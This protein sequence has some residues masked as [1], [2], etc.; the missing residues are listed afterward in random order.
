MIQFLKYGALALLS[1]SLILT[2]V[3]VGGVVPA[4][5]L[6]QLASYV[7]LLSEEND[8]AEPQEGI[9]AEQGRNTPNQDNNE[10]EKSETEKIAAADP[11]QKTDDA[12]EAG[13]ETGLASESV[14]DETAAAASPPSFDLL[15][16]EPDGSLVVSGQS[17]RGFTVELL[18]GMGRS[19]G[20]DI[21]GG[22]GDFVII[23][24][25]RLAVGD[26]TL[27]LAITG[28]D[29]R[30]TLSLDTGVIHIPEPGKK[31]VLALVTRPDEPSRIVVKPPALTPADAGPEEN[32]ETAALDPASIQPT[33]V[34]EAVS[35]ETANR[36]TEPAAA[37]EN[38]A[39]VENAA[40]DGT[41]KT[42]ASG[43]IDSRVSQE[44]PAGDTKADD[45]AKPVDGNGEI[46]PSNPPETGKDLSAPDTGSDP[47]AVSVAPIQ[48]ASLPD[49]KAAAD[50]RQEPTGDSAVAAPDGDQQPTASVVGSDTGRQSKQAAAS[51]EQTPDPP[52]ENLPLKV[53]VEAVEIE[54]DQLFIAGAVDAG[55]RVRLYLDGELVGSA[56]GTPDGRFLLARPFDLK[57]GEHT[58]RADVIDES[59]ARVTARAEVGL[60]HEPAPVELALANEPG[61]DAGGA[62]AGQRQ[63]ESASNA[64]P[65]QP[66]GDLDR[67]ENAVAQPIVPD[68]GVPASQAVVVDDTAAADV[69]EQSAVRGNE[70]AAISDPVVANEES[71][72]PRSQDTTSQGDTPRS[73]GKSA[74]KAERTGSGSNVETAT[75]GTAPTDEPALDNANGSLAS[76]S[77]DAGASAEQ[78]TGKADRPSAEQKRREPFQARSAPENIIRTGTAVIIKPGDN[79]WRISRKTYGRGIRYTTIFRANREQIRNP[80][81][82]YAGQVFKVPSAGLDTAVE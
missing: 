50:N 12:G 25:E 41:A 64:S 56:L 8:R 49:Q 52:Q 40:I 10:T 69:N 72:E 31:G 1:A 65:V 75:T 13:A 78:P 33:A 58:I 17:R 36:D 27:K 57:P 19:L 3:V 35:D 43:Q 37:G 28:P 5:K 21:A 14:S 16:V 81:L 82:I 60:V 7:P 74:R 63:A 47:V 4:D 59:T 18:D 66:D 61:N 22:A 76:R 44:R 51:K 26:H 48:V 38:E 42:A 55:R 45:V 32:V 29:G 73:D 53:L 11:S 6:A 68:P 15:R 46:A 34:P 62:E 24:D 23:P 80:N 70:T 30:Q 71:A 67:S 20:K 77:A 9:T 79:L 54:G 2:A 39:V